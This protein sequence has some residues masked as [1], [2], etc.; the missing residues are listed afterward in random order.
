MSRGRS[1]NALGGGNVEPW[2]GLAHARPVPGR[3][4]FSE[5]TKGV[6]VNM[7]ALASDADH[8]WTLVQQDLLQDDLILVEVEDLDTVRAYRLEDRMSTDLEDLVSGLSSE[9]SVKADVFSPYENDDA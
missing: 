4:P 1:P 7:V 2:I 9:V 6:Y 3:R 8:F 5:R